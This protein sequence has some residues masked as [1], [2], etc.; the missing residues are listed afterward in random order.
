M[1]DNKQPGLVEGGE[2]GLTPHQS[3]LKYLP[4][5]LLPFSTCGDELLQSGDRLK[6]AISNKLPTAKNLTL[7][8]CPPLRPSGDTYLRGVCYFFS[9]Q[10]LFWPNSLLIKVRDYLSWDHSG[11]SLNFFFKKQIQKCFESIVPPSANQVVVPSAG[12]PLLVRVAL[13]QF[14]AWRVWL[15]DRE[16]R[17]YIPCWPRIFRLPTNFP[18]N[19]RKLGG[20]LCECGP[21]VKPRPMLKKNNNVSKI[22]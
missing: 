2:H 4:S 12:R 20:W 8:P 15:N 14:F 6:Q 18:G 1:R 11:R 9:T 22:A 7:G 5:P 3:L 21:K 10:D 13:V 16:G 19:F 17:R